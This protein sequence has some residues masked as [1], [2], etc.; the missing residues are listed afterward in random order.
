MK[1]SNNV[2]PS[3]KGLEN[4]KLDKANEGSQSKDI[5][6]TNIS[7]TK[8]SSVEI[9]SRA[10]MMNKAKSIASEQNVD[11][12]KVDRLQKLIDSGSYNIDAASIADRLVD[13]HM[14]MGE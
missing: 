8:N 11:Q 10:Q 13:E 2:N 9:S 4:S 1:V 14:L 5:S 6:S 7:G 3:I 12:A